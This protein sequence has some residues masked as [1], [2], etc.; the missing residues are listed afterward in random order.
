MIA[1]PILTA[2]KAMIDGMEIAVTACR[3]GSEATVG[4]AMP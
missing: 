2:V 1:A 3:A 4:S